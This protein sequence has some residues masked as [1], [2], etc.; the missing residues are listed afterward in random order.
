M[1]CKQKTDHLQYI[2]I[3]GL[4]QFVKCFAFLINEKA[5]PSC[6]W[7]I[8]SC[9]LGKSDLNRHFSHHQ[10][11][12]SPHLLQLVKGVTTI[13]NYLDQ[14]YLMDFLTIFMSK[15]LNGMILQ[16]PL[17]SSVFFKKFSV[18]GAD[19]FRVGVV[20]VWFFPVTLENLLPPVKHRKGPLF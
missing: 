10:L 1:S 14:P 13:Y 19:T 12:G 18:H 16:E 6:S 2:S 20:L 5:D 11:G 7:T 9:T 17:K 3:F 8:T 15:L 4:H